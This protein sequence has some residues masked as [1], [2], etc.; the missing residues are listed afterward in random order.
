MSKRIFFY[1]Y[2][3]AH[4][5]ACSNNVCAGEFCVRSDRNFDQQR[6]KEIFTFLTS[7]GINFSPR[8]NG[9]MGAEI[10]EV[11]IS[12]AIEDDNP[13]LKRAR[14]FTLLR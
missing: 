6:D 5:W 1:W 7:R 3:G 10:D 12:G 11:I 13:D 8:W 2:W 4:E 14:E 9:Y